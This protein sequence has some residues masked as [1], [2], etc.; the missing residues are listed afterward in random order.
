[1]IF[2]ALASFL[3]ISIGLSVGLL[4]GVPISWAG[5][6]DFSAGYYSIKAQTSRETGSVS[7]L[8]NYSAS[9]RIELLPE[10]ELGLGYSLTAAKVIGGDLSFGPDFGLYYFP[11]TSANIRRTLGKNFVFEVRE[12]V[13]PFISGSFHHRQYQSTQSNY[14][15][16]G[17]GGG[18]EWQMSSQRALTTSLRILSLAGPSSARAT[19]IDLSVGFAFPLFMD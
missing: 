3:Q 4:L 17:F 1:M 8:G 9:Y 13:R 7:N 18:A 10:V 11:V 14:V 16:F 5:K 12:Q 2:R 6:V 19:E 15:G